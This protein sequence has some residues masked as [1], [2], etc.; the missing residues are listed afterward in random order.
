VQQ[1]L[2]RWRR[3]GA[4][5]RALTAGIALAA[6]FA[7]ALAAF[8]QRDARIALY[9]SPLRPEQ[10]TEVV[11]RLAEW[12]VAFIALPDNVRVDSRSRNELLLR[13]SLAGAPHAHRASSS[14]AL[15]KINPLVPQS[16]LDAQ[17]REGLAGDLAAALRGIAGVEDA[18]IL[19]APA[20][21]GGFA[22][23]AQSPAS[24]GVRLRIR[25]GARLAEGAVD[26][27][28]QFVADSVPGLEPARVAILDDNGIALGNESRGADEQ[29][30]TLQGSLQSELDQA[31][32]AGATIVRVRF[33]YDRRVRELRNVRR[34]PLAGKSIATAT[35]DEHYSND[36]KRYSKVHS[37]EDR[38][39]DVREE[40]T[41]IPGGA[42]QFVSA[43]VAVDASRQLDLTAIRALASASLGLV[44]NRDR[45]EVQALPFVHAVVTPRSPVWTA[46]GFVATL[47]PMFLIALTLL[48]VLR[49]GAAPV[50]R[51]LET[52]LD[53]IA[54]GRTSRAIAT[55]PPSHVRGALRDE[56]PHTAAAI[57]SAL[58]AATASAV[59]EMYSPEE[60]AA[61][62][63]RMQREAAPAVPNYET[64]LRRG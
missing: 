20:R 10:V 24:A 12:N 6:L 30:Q 16:V 13:L 58:P 21:S 17:Q 54:V 36:R 28:R 31:F 51:M 23:E 38:G 32:G 46:F 55:Y 62:V 39:S 47:A 44:P 43:S 11:Q 26:G 45:L 25:A 18:Q 49:W 4:R 22:D 50:A 63:R 19:I 2:V 37:S 33:D 1:L 56:P 27:I 14:E 34:A 29:A 15:E 57:I 64:V 35:L 48:L 8:L 9:P 7:F 60:R 5:Q 59:L 3:L 53:K 41:Q 42:L 40:R 52:A 61:I